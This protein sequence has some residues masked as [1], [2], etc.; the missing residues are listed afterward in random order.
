MPRP[1]IQLIARLAH[2]LG[3]VVAVALT[4]LA[5]LGSATAQAQQSMATLKLKENNKLEANGNARIVYEIKLPQAAYTQLKKNT[6]NTALFIRKLGLTN[7][8]MLIEDVKG[9]W[10]DGE[11]TL[12]I[13]F[14]ALGIA[15]AV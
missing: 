3:K 1:V 7:Q 12:R 8:N 9:E 15:R 13:E 11:S 5:L 4:G 6:P 14:T 2:K 10:L